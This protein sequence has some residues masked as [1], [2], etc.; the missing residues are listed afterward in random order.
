[1][2]GTVHPHLQD[3][4]ADLAAGEIG[5]EKLTFVHSDKRFFLKKL[6][7]KQT[8]NLYVFRMKLLPVV[9]KRKKNMDGNFL[10]KVFHSHAKLRT[11][12]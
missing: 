6:Q 4:F 11:N 9:K 2:L 3:F 1:M 8:G 7:A 5:Q 12:L 10:H